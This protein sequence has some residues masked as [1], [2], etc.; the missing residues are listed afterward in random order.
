[1]AKTI[2]FYGND[3]KAANDKYQNAP[4]KESFQIIQAEAYQGERLEGDSI[5]FMDDVS[6]GDRARITELW[7]KF[8]NRQSFDQTGATGDGKRGMGGTGSLGGVERTPA[9][10]RRNLNPATRVDDP[11]KT[12]AT[13]LKKPG[14]EK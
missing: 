9:S 2:V 5:Q 10:D 8:D 14:F 6:E 11:A 1:M 4:E 13:P 12:E 3:N 7:G